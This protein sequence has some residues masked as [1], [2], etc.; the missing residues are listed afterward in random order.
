M[1]SIKKRSVVVT[2]VAT[3]LASTVLVSVSAQ[4]AN[5]APAASAAIKKAMDTPTTLT[6]WSWLP[7]QQNQV[8]LFTAKYPKIKVKLV[9]V[10][11]GG[12]EY[13][14]IKAG[15]AAKAGLPDVAQIE[16][17]YVPT[18]KVLNGL[19]NIAPYL[20][21]TWKSQFPAW[22]SAQVTD[23]NGGVWAVPQDSGPMGLLYRSDV[24]AANK[25]TPPKT[26]AEFATAAA[27]LHKADAKQYISNMVMDS[28]N[29]NGLYWQAGARP[30]KMTSSTAINI[31]LNDAAT[32]KVTKF[33]GDLLAA[34]NLPADPYWTSDW[35]AAFN[36]GKF[37][38]W[39]AAAWGIGTVAAAA[40]D[41]K[42]NWRSAPLPTWDGKPV[43]GNWG[44]STVAVMSTSKNV[45][46]AAVLADFVN[47]D[48]AAAVSLTKP[49]T[50]DFPVVNTVLSSAAFS[51]GTNEFYGGTTVQKN[52]ADY[53]ATVGKNYEWSPFQDQV[54][55]YWTNDVL[56]AILKK[57]D[58][59]AAVDKWQAD[60]VAY[61]KAQGYTVT[62]N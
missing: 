56:D 52:F 44:G 46:A 30:F 17:Q 45:I 2:A 24:F 48:Q 62:T 32:K 9:N 55:T 20:S 57:T 53:N 5:A 27:T 14:K 59:A 29:M 33:W 51:S 43:S 8:D 58:T 26:W 25:I 1:T 19:A 49:P 34:G 12:A 39:P 50:G 35:N 22:I 6:F 38:S 54:Y 4:S 61:A 42:G 28:G 11:S 36:K 16:F 23:S 18:F 47:T 60:T 15:L 31:K 21:R 41:T 3:L 7:G 13:S 40:A 37:L 10:G